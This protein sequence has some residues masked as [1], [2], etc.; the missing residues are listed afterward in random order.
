MRARAQRDA[1]LLTPRPGTPIYGLAAP[2]LTS[3]AVTQ[4][5]LSYEQWTAVTLTYGQ[6]DRRE[7]PC[8]AVTTIAIDAATMAGPESA[9]A[10]GD[11]PETEL[12]YA[13]GGELNR[14][15]GSVSADATEPTPPLV[16]TRETLPRRSDRLGDARTRRGLA[17]TG[18]R[19]C[20]S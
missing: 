1:E 4:Y 8:V 15:A 13:V 2:A 14:A 17:G 10:P 18:M 9:P 20:Y 16:V 6:S 5:Q 7:G 11:D 19:G 12:R 3:A